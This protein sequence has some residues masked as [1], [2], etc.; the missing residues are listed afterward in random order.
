LKCIGQGQQGNSP[1]FAIFVNSDGKGMP[2]FAS[3]GQLV[4]G[5]YRLVKIQVESV[6][7]EYS[8]GRG[9]QTIPIRGQ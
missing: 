1:K 3:E 4:F 5:Q 2:V 9:R 8:D 7:M 6:V